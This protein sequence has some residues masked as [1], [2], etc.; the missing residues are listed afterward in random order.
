[1]KNWYSE[2]NQYISRNYDRTILGIRIA[3]RLIVSRH[4]MF[5]TFLLSLFFTPIVYFFII[6]GTEAEIP[7]NPI[8]LFQVIGLF[9]VIFY[10]FMV[11]IMY[12]SNAKR[13]KFDLKRG[14]YFVGLQ[15]L[16][17]LGLVL[18]LFT[19]ILVSDE[20]SLFLYLF[21]V[22]MAYS[23]FT[24]VSLFVSYRTV[25]ILSHLD[26][27]QTLLTNLHENGDDKNIY[28]NKMKAVTCLLLL[29]EK[30]IKKFN[31]RFTANYLLE[32]TKVEN[33]ELLAAKILWLDVEDEESLNEIINLISEAI[34]ERTNIYPDSYKF[35]SFM[36]KIR[37]IANED[38]ELTDSI[39]GKYHKNIFFT[40]IPVIIAIINLIPILL[41]YL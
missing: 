21:M 2:K 33:L 29:K 31:S 20:V 27:A 3:N 30:L 10:L 23:I 15:S 37:E 5:N 32:F 34:N 16:K 24:L 39:T 12:I 8:E 26:Y 1:L 18:Y 17:F 7:N 4:E 36:K 9:L 41:K 35:D 28:A 13:Y 22:L 25:S 14:I 11:F 6:L 19:M 40:V 38:W